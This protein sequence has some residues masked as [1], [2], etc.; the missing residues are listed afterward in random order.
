[1]KKL[2]GIIVLVFVILIGSSIGI[3]FYLMRDINTMD[4]ITIEMIDLSIVDDGT[5]QGA[6]NHGRFSNTV[7]VTVLNQEIIG[8][9]VINDLRFSKDDV[10]QAFID[11]VMASQ[12]LDIDGLAGG[13]VSTNAYLKALEKALGGN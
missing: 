1:M 7:E 2:I 11:Q 5:Y 4:N 9:K 13:T 12:S 6:F 8:V 3:L 10:K